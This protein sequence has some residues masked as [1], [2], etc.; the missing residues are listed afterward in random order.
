[1]IDH[2]AY[3]WWTPAIAYLLSVTGSFIGLRFALLA[4]D[5]VGAGRWL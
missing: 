1:M 5:A 3:G 4:R 2:F